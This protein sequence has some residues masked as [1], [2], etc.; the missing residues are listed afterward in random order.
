MRV[1]YRRQDNGRH[2]RLTIWIDGENVGTLTVDTGEEERVFDHLESTLRVLN[3][4]ESEEDLEM[5]IN[6]V[7]SEVCLSRSRLEKVRR[8]LG[9]PPPSGDGGGRSKKSKWSWNKH[10]VPIKKHLLGAGGKS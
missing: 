10:V 1:T 5:D 9:L 6:Q 2:A 7:M 8:K 3:N 4:D